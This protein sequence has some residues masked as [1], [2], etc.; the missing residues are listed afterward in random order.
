[1]RYTALFILSILVAACTAPVQELDMDNVL[2]WCIVPFDIKKRT[3]EQRIEM[4]KDLGIK[5]YAYDWREEHLDEMAKEMSLAKENDINVSSV[6]MWLD[7]S[8]D[9][10]GNLSESNNRIFD[11]V[12]SENL[13]TD[14]WL[15]FN[16]NY[17]EG[18]EDDAAVARG[19]KIISYLHN[20]AAELDCRVALYNHGDWFGEPINQIKILKAA[21][22]EKQVGLIYNFHHGHHQIDGFEDLVDHMLPYLWTV[23]LNGMEKNGSKILPIGEGDYESDM[24][25]TLLD[26]GYDG[27]FGVLGH[28]DTA[29]VKLILEGNLGGLQNMM[30]KLD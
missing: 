3:P 24:L 20:R 6:W 28:V 9:S 2:A 14:I 26:K 23:N 29:D 11:I 1:M 16:S 19:V 17:F 13:K 22:L 12:K 5:N 25:S 27:P 21:N 10:V 30:S 4:L 8:N 15:G 18:L 7:I